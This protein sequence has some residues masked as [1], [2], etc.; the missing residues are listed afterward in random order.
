MAVF[1]CAFFFEGGKEKDPG[2]SKNTQKTPPGESGT[3]GR[4]DTSIPGRGV[5][6][7]ETKEQHNTDEI[8][9]RLKE[10]E[11]EQAMLDRRRVLVEALDR[12]VE[13][14]NAEINMPC[15]FRLFF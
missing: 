6:V 13:R 8:P 3:E 9:R 14:F 2:K 7:E 11:L 5:R 10:A 12:R 4:P 1:F 15:Y